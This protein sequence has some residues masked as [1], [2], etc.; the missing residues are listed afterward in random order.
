MASCLLIAVGSEHVSV[1]DTAMW[2]MQVLPCMGL[3]CKRSEWGLKSSLVVHVDLE[4]HPSR[5]STFSVLTETL[6][7]LTMALFQSL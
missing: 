6:Y 2:V 7:M 1:M 5:G 4:L 3:P